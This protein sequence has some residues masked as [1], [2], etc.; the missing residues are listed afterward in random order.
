MKNPFTTNDAI[1]NS[2]YLIPNIEN[3][4]VASDKTP[5]SEKHQFIHK[6]LRALVT[7]KEFPCIG[8]KAA[9]SA[10]TYRI[11]IYKSMQEE[12]AILGVCHDLVEFINEQKSMP[13][14]FT[15]YIACFENTIVNSEDHFEEL[16]WGLLQNLHDK[17]KVFF[18]WDDTIS[19]DPDNPSFTICFGEVAFFLVGMHPASS[20]FARKFAYPTVVF[21][22][23]YQFEKL[24]EEGRFEN[25]K[26]VIREKDAK[27]NDGQINPNLGDLHAVSAA[28]QFGTKAK[29]SNW[30]CPFK[31]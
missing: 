14:N 16:L 27:I 11:G 5:L 29:E 2:C 15:T 21:N 30:K 18:K 8:A 12:G 10:G 28:G 6:Q 4:S 25:M 31:H 9:F 17:D 22:A 3:G 7:S 24:K 1:N 19:K 26:K 20:R 13:G 23:Q